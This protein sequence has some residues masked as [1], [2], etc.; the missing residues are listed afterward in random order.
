[1]IIDGNQLAKKLRGEVAAEVEK[2]RAAT[3]CQPHLAAI[4]VGEDPASAIYVRYKQKDCEKVGIR[5]TLYKLPATTPEEELFS[6]VQKCNED[7]SIHGILVQLP[8][9]NQIETKRILD[10]ISPLKDVDAFH[11]TNVGL[12]MQG[13]PRFLPCTPQGVQYMLIESGVPTEGAHVVVLGR[14]NIVGKPMAAMMFQKGRGANATVT[15]CHS[16]TKNLKEIAST[17][18]ILIAAIGSPRFVTAEMVKPQAVV[19]DVGINSVNGKLVGDVDF[20]T[21]K[22]IASAISPVPGGVGP[23]TRA[24]LLKNTLMAAESILSSTHT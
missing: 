16:R 14:S 13:R 5:S 21:V 8:L 20:E 4:L 15:V 12:M 11:P 2:F 17:A 18:D 6:L 10:A 22:E 9:P 23:M 1:M 3:N 7:E 24:M 19:I